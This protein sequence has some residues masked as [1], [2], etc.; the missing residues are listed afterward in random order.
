[1]SRFS[2]VGDPLSILQFGLAPNS[3]EIRAYALNSRE[4][5]TKLTWNMT[6]GV[7]SMTTLCANLDF[8]S[9]AFSSF[10]S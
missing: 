1:M 7:I 8:N 3:P 9:S 5:Q 4:K 10:S 6:R 2:R